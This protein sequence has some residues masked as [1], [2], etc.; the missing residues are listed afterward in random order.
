MRGRSIPCPSTVRE[1]AGASQGRLGDPLSPSAVLS[2]GAA[3]TRVEPCGRRRGEGAEQQVPRSHPRRH[4]S[5]HTCLLSPTQL[6]LCPSALRREE[7]AGEERRRPDTLQLWQERE[8]RQQQQQQQSVVWGAPRKDR[9][10]SSGG[11]AMG[12]G[13][14]PPR[15]SLSLGGGGALPG[16]ADPASPSFSSFLKLG[17][18]AAGGGPGAS[19]T[20]ATYKYVSWTPR[21]SVPTLRAHPCPNHPSDSPSVFSAARPGPTPPSWERQRGREPPPLP[22]PPPPRSPR[23]HLDQVGGGLWVEDGGLCRWEGRAEAW[24]PEGGVGH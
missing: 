17:V 2:S 18:R 9:C 15:A 24:R 10:A 14:E 12:A 13:R 6:C 22:L 11:L 20:Q 3:A 8:R 23:F 1:P 19:S 16:T 7:P 4:P 21:L 5:L